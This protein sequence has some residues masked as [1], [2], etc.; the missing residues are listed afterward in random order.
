VEVV[1][2]AVEVGGHGGDGVE[3]V[4]DALGLTHL[5]AAILRWRMGSSGARRSASVMGF[6]ANLG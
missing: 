2:R 6:G 3:A 5:D 4:L 1:V